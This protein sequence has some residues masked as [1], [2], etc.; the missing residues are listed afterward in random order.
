[1]NKKKEETTTK[2]SI[3]ISSIEKRE[4]KEEKKTLKVDSFNGGSVQ[5][6]RGNF[7]SLTLSFCSI[8]TIAHGVDDTSRL[9]T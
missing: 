5:K 3:D 9:M 7:F 4:E 8:Y 1:M 2:K 6:N